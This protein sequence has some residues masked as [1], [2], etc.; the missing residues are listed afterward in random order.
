MKA[1][2]GPMRLYITVAGMAFGLL[3]AWAILVQ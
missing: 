2:G 1:G 3:A